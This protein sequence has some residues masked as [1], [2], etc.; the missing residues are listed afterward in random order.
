MKVLVVGATGE[1]G[2]R[3]VQELVNQKIPVRAMVRDLERG[4][5][6]L[7]EGIELVVADLQQKSTLDTAIA[8]CDYII[9]AAASRP[10]NILGFFLVDYV[11]TKNLIEIAQTKNIKQFVLVTSLCVSKFFHPLNIFGLVLF[12]KKQAEAF[13]IGSNLNYTIVR[14]AGL[15][16][17]AIAPVVLSG[18]DTLFEGRIPRQLVAEICVAALDDPNT[19]KQIIEAATDTTAPEKSYKELFKAI[20]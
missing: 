8:D 2:R 11:G 15:N 18:A 7:P 12:W 5:E 6:L 4:N 13:L 3:V 14:P 19:N 17:E 10:P 9:S 16:T 20:A 1:T